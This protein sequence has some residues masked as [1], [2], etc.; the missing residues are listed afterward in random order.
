MTSFMSLSLLVLAS[1][2]AFC[3]SQPSPSNGNYDM[4]WGTSSYYAH[5]LDEATRNAWLDGLQRDGARIIRI[6]INGISPGTYKGTNITV[7]IPNLEETVGIFNDTV[8]DAIDDLFM[9]GHRRG[10]KFIVSVH[11]GN[12]FGQ[13][14]CDAYCTEFGGFGPASG[15]PITLGNSF[16]TDPT[17]VAAFDSRIAHI[18]NYQSPNFGKPWAQLTEAIAAFDIENEPMIQAIT[19]LDTVGP[20]WFCD[21]ARQFKKYIGSAAI[22]VSTGGAGGSGNIYQNWNWRPWLFTCPEI[23]WIAL[24]GYDGDWTQ[25]VPNATAL[26]AQ[27]NKKL[28]VEE[29]GVVASARA[30]NLAWNFEK[31]VELGLSWVYWELVPGPIKSCF[32]GSDRSNA[33]FEVQLDGPDY[34]GFQAIANRTLTAKSAYDFS[35]Y[36]AL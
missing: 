14:S 25:W 17:A 24:H 30:N 23:D 26:A 34:A 13:N 20:A 11:D 10:I 33:V 31:F 12:A 28:F 21:R 36:L 1:L 4:F 18:M 6:W 29:W 32:C 5:G 22:A 2:F 3:T 16:Y 19:Q 9:E 27:Y 8:L 15:T 35:A 7:T